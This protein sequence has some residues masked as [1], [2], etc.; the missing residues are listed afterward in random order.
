MLYIWPCSI[1]VGIVL[2]VIP[3]KIV[4]MKTENN[5]DANNVVIGGIACCHNDNLW[6]RQRRHRDKSGFPVHPIRTTFVRL[7]IS[8]QAQ[9]H[10][11]HMAFRII[12]REWAHRLEGRGAPGAGVRTPGTYLGIGD[13]E[14]S[15]IATL[16]SFRSLGDLPENM[17]Q[18]RKEDSRKQSILTPNK[19]GGS[20]Y[21]IR[22][23][24]HI[25]NEYVSSAFNSINSNMHMA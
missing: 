12:C 11:V 4:P 1:F 17:L 19:F 20:C 24:I 16:N 7:T 8:L 6:C 22:R 5:H 15:T 2:Y 13:A 25:V 23:I 18:W 10:C 9:Q 21:D 3:C 14:Y